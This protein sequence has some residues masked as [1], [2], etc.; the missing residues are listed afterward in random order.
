MTVTIEEASA[1]L[2]RLVEKAVSGEE[3]I[4]AGNSATAIRLTPFALPDAAPRPPRVPGMDKGKFTVPPEFFDPLPDDILDDFY[5][6][7]IFPCKP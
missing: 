4:I 6:G 1:Q 3:I 2:A 5:N 7:E